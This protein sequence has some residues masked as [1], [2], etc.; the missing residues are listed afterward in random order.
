MKKHILL[1]IDGLP[2]GGAENVTLT[3]AKGLQ[4]RDC[5][6]TLLSLSDRLDYEIPAGV[7]YIVDHDTNSGPFRKTHE[8]SRRAASMDRLLPGLFAEFGKPALV[9]SHL[10]KTDRIVVRSRVLRECNVWYCVHGMFSRTY[11]GNKTG[12]SRWLKQ[13]KVQKVYRNRKVI[14]VSE[15][16]GTDLIE[17]SGIR[18]EKLITI[19]NPFNIKEIENRAV[20]EN[21][22]A[23]EDYILHVGRFHQVKRHDRLLAAFALAD[24]PAK[25]VLIG[26][27]EAAVTHAIQ[28][29]ITA[30][31]LQDKVVLAGFHANP[32]PAIKGAKMV[33]LSSDS[34]G[35]PTVLIEAL[36]CHTPIVST[37]CPG[38]VAEIMSGA[39]QPYLAEMNEQALAEKMRLAWQTPPQIT[40]EM[41]SKFDYEKILDK[42]LSL[43]E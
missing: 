31:N 19:Y 35:L 29:K 36:I 20:Q 6:V 1:I 16:I 23:G 40:A 28:E 10:H 33:A 13:K 34:E 18:P 27:G 7:N 43:A 11:L 42:Y 12:F 15:A 2:G 8:L 17:Q 24:L 21:P 14:T 26:Q 30:L 37:A 32:L 9:I 3:L 41:Y 22:F 39:L 5:A 38:G 4:Q 25:L